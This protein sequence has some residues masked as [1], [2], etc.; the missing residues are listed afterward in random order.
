M[1]DFQSILKMAK[2]SAL[3]VRNPNCRKNTGVLD[4]AIVQV[5]SDVSLVARPSNVFSLFVVP[6]SNVDIF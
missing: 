3:Q 2:E 6:S 1:E 4:Y 5:I